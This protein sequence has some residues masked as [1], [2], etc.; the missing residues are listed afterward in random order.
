MSM[1]VIEATFEPALTEQEIMHYRKLVACADTVKEAID[2]LDSIRESLRLE[3]NAIDPELM[4]ELI[5]DPT[6]ADDL[7]EDTAQAY[8]SI[9]AL[10]LSRDRLS[11]SIKNAKSTIL[12]FLFRGPSEQLMMDFRDDGE[13]DWEAV[14]ISV[15]DLPDKIIDALRDGGYDTLGKLSAL[16]NTPNWVRGVNGIGPAKEQVVV[17]AL[18]A[19]FA[20]HVGVAE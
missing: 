12:D 18:Q 6:K 15:L 9:K 3:M 14:A 11:K 17:D 19:F 2:R 20:E 8:A 10:E 1:D 5:V 7:D 4:E 13:P 16:V